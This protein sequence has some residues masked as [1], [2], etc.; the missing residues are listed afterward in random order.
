[1][2][3]QKIVRVRRNYN[4]WVA[5]QTMEDFSLRFTAKKARKW[6]TLRVGNTALGAISFLAL[7]SI[8]A[9]ITLQY[10]FVNAMAAIFAVCVLIFATGLPISYYAAKHGRIPERSATPQT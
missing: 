4:I 3:P 2:L 1:M 8:G 10:G 6:S 5:N 9:S 7:E